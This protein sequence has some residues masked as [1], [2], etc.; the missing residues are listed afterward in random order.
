MDIGQKI[1]QA[2]LEAGLSQRQLCG[3][4]VTRNMLSLIESGRARPGMDTLL[5][6]AERLGKPVSFFLEE[7]AVVLPNRQVMD[8][9]RQAFDRDAW[10]AAL[11][12]LEDYQAPDS[13]FDRERYLLEGLCLL[14]LA[15]V[16]LGE[17]KTAYARSLLERAELAEEKTPYAHGLSRRRLL[18]S[19]RAWP[20][21]ADQFAS[22]LPD[23]SGEVLTRAWAAFCRGEYARCGAVLEAA[24]IRQPQWYLL[25]GMAALELGVAEDGAEYLHR[26]EEAFPEQ[27][28]ALLERCYRELGDYKMAYEYAVKRRKD[29]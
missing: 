26:A 13:V 10:A 4:T 18:L 20:E 29:P 2:R 11:A 22:V 6:F 21:Q 23:W 9:A 28:A 19:A 15:A 8:D 16:A 27:T 17:E 25:R 24:D 5:A 3:D 7:E 1:K 12:A 14:E